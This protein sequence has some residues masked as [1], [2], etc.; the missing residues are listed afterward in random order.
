[1]SKNNLKVL[2]SGGGTAG[3]IFPIVAVIKE[4]QKISSNVE[5]RYIGQKGGSDKNLIKKEL[6]SLRV[7]EIDTEKFARNFRWQTFLL[8]YKIIKGYLE[9]KK[10]LRDFDPDIVFVKGG[11]VSYPVA[12]AARS[13][14]IPILLHETDKKMGLANKMIAKFAQKIATSFKAESNKGVWVG[15]PIREEFWKALSTETNPKTIT[16]IGGSQ[17]AHAINK[18]IWQILPQ[19]V[20]DYKIIHITGKKDIAKAKN[21]L[22]HPNYNPYDFIVDISKVLAK[23]SLIISRSGGTIFEIAALGKPVILIPLP[24][25][26]NDHQR[27]NAKEFERQNS[28]VYLEQNNLTA[29]ELLSEI[30]SLLKNQNKC[31]LL[32]K[33]IKK[34]ASRDSAFKLA[35][36]ILKLGE[37]K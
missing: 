17:G 31:K 4:L 30:N 3:H 5:I 24:S 21:I 11:Y 8:P 26:A 13:R 16:I 27:A 23:S 35:E 37:E 2:V 20:K 33:N 12:L 7:Y 25:S 36:L 18:L 15:N 9:S 6:P 29:N 34:F 19:L 22:K 28:A 32:S 14:N 1:M 10:I